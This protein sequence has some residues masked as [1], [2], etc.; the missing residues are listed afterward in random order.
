MTAAKLFKVTYW[1]QR[2]SK[3]EDRGVYRLGLFKHHYGRPVERAV[4]D[5]A[6]ENGEVFVTQVQS[7]FPLDKPWLLYHRSLK[8]LQ[9]E[10]SELKQKISDGAISL[11]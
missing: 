11:L 6:I 3:V 8:E 10:V 9:D 1:N 7:S 4:L 2:T 5:E